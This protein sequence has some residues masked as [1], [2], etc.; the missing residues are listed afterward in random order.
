MRTATPHRA[1]ANPRASAAATALAS[2]GLYTARDSRDPRVGSPWIVPPLRWPGG[3]GCHP[4][5]PPS[6]G[7]FF[8]CHSVGHPG[9]CSGSPSVG[10]FWRAHPWRFWRAS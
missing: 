7:H 1:H 3:P 10:H 4:G 6:S 9:N 2:R 8:A 5:P